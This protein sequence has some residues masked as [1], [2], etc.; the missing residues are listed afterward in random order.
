MFGLVETV[1]ERIWSIELDGRTHQVRVDHGYWSGNTVLRVDDE[2]V[3][4]DSPGFAGFAD[5]WFDPPEQVTSLGSHEL[6]LRIIPKLSYEFDLIVDGISTSD[7]KGLP[8][9]PRRPNDP[10]YRLGKLGASIGMVA[11]P[12]LIV[13]SFIFGRFAPGWGPRWFAANDLALASGIL[14]LM[15]GMGIYFG[16]RARV[17]SSLGSRVTWAI[18]GLVTLFVATAA[19]LALPVQLAEVVGQPETL[20]VTVV[21]SSTGT[22]KGAPTVRTADGAT[23]EW[24]W[25]FG[26]YAY[27]QIKPGRYEIVITPARHRLVAIRPAT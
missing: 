10:I 14:P 11:M 9:L 17:R 24:V 18:F 27:P 8:P 26:Q 1:G 15:A 23:Y 21:E 3:I 4:H 19:A 5:H 12:Y 6:R 2:V 22:S 16:N 7:G 13:V 25:S 20:T